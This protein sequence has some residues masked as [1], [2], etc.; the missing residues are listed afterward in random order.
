MKI[1][2]DEL[3]MYATLML[4]VLGVMAFVV[5]VITQVIKNLPWFKDI[6][7]SVVVFVLSLI[8]C[9]T[10]LVA[11]LAW[12]DEPIAWYMIFACV[13]AA[14]MVALISMDGWER[15][16]EIWNRSKFKSDKEN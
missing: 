15:V 10:T 5:S 3:M 13:V 2:M 4:M 7:T 11:L 16:A 6:P 8:L 9:P 12:L 1:T 14:F